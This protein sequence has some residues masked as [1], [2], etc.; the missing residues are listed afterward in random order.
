MALVL[1]SGVGLSLMG[2]IQQNLDALQ[3]LRGFYV[4][5]EARRAVLDWSRGM[6]PT[7]TP[8]G[9]AVLGDL[10]L[11]WKATPSREPVTQIGYPQGVGLHD[12]A[13]YD[14]NVTVYRGREQTPWF[15]EQIVRVGHRKARD[16]RSPFS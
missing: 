9:D 12:L 16:Q 4:Q 3:R 7:Q 11:V 13:L 1:L 8:G 5:L 10:R 15:V 14:V 2:W 6:N